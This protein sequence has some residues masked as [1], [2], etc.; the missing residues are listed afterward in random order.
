L[1][2]SLLSFVV[3]CALAAVLTP[4]VRPLLVRVGVLDEPNARSLHSGPVPRGGGIAVAIGTLAAA[5]FSGWDPAATGLSIVAVLLGLIGGLD[6]RFH[7]SARVRLGAQLVVPALAMPLLFVGSSGATGR[8]IALGALAVVWCSAYVNAFNF[9]DGINGLSVGQTLV[10]GVSLGW[11]ADYVGEPVLVSCALAVAGAALGFLPYNAPRAS[12]FLGDVGSYFLGA[13]LSLLLVALVVNGAPVLVAMGPFVLYLV[14]T[15]STLVRR[16]LRRETLWSAHREHA[17]Q[18]LVQ[19]GW[20][21]SRVALLAVAVM[22]ISSLLL[23]A[24]V[25]SAAVLQVGAM[26]VAVAV[27]AGFVVLPS[28]L[29]DQHRVQA[30]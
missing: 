16:G 27:S 5:G 28:L 19:A 14:D 9:M 17:Y 1:P 12:V 21:H 6:D 7:L 10:A 29:G 11:L 24:T 30:S 23:N 26:M 25:S 20:S 15:G 2:T 18:R 4:T 3:G 8:M 13:W 22:A